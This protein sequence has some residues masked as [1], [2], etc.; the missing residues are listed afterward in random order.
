MSWAL[1]IVGVASL[2]VMLHSHRPLRWPGTLVVQAWIASWLVIELGIHVAVAVT[3]AATCLALAGGLDGPN[4]A[5]GAAGLAMSAVAALGLAYHGWRARHTA[6]QVDDALREAFG[7]DP[8]LIADD[9]GDDDRP[10]A[11]RI[12]R[13]LPIRHPQV[14]RTGSLPYSAGGRRMTLDVYRRAGRR[15]GD[16]STGRPVLLYVHGGGWVIGNKRQQGLLTVNHLAARGWVC[17]SINYRLSP[18]A[19]F[20]EHIIDVKRALCW[21]KEH[22]ADYGGDPDFVVICGGSA[23]AHLA[24]LT[25]LTPG[26]LEYQREH[27]DSDTSVQGCVGY[28][29]VYDFCDRHGH[30][31][32]RAFRLLLEQAIMKCRFDR[33]RDS[34]ER[35]SPIARVG[36]HAPPFFLLHGDRDNL[37]PV[38]ESRRFADALR[39][40]SRHPVAYAELAGAQHAFE[41]L[42]SVRSLAAVD[43]VGR[44]CQ[45]IYARHLEARERARA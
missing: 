23:G 7:D 44:F 29:G 16:E 36:D 40:V 42:P 25:A 35:A 41:L 30:W 22:A 26:D 8:L 1:F 33:A 2:L 24:A 12:A 5:W 38:D 3:G 27:P 15:R 14:E 32:H 31:P 6:R 11:L 34:F 4:A 10:R 28:Y 19:T 20:P 9:G 13:I 21:V 45:I 37:S 18:R 43:A 39:A 17:F